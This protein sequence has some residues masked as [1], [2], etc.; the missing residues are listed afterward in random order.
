MKERKTFEERLKELIVKIDSL[1]LIELK[2]YRKELIERL[3][4][5]DD[6]M[7]EKEVQEIDS[8]RKYFHE[9]RKR[10]M[11]PALKYIKDRIK[12]FNVVLCNGVNK[13]QS[14]K[15][16]DIAAKV[17]PMETFQHIYGL[18]MLDEEN[19]NEKIQ[20]FIDE[21]NKLI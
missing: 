15:F 10:V 13:K 16:I 6:I 14:T 3:H 8:K 4:N 11:K 9:L 18:T 5:I 17:L 2:T 19:K 20:K 12:L 1:N 7:K 21:C